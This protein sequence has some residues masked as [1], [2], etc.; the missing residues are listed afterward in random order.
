M[1]YFNLFQGMVYASNMGTSSILHQFFSH[2]ISVIESCLDSRARLKPDGTCAET[3]FRLS[4][5]WRSPFKLAGES[6][7]L[8]AGS[9]SVYI[10]VSN[11]GYSMF[12]GSVRVL[13]T[14][15]I[16]QFPLH[17]PSCASPCA[18][19][20]QTSYTTLQPPPPHPMFTRLL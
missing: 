1:C 4:P 18:I 20:F 17:V 5:K 15:S 9:Q 19:R 6:V 10:S 3:R 12:R 7:Q 16:C 14:H 2:F 13:A 8:T 11:V